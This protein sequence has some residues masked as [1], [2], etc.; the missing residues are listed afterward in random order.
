MLFPPYPILLGLSPLHPVS[1]HQFN[2]LIKLETQQ[3]ETASYPS[4]FLQIATVS[5]LDSHSYSF[6]VFA[7]YPIL[8]GPPRSKYRPS[9][10]RPPPLTCRTWKNE[11]LIEHEDFRISTRI[12]K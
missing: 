8:P 2:K 9:H 7:S 11:I 1:R 10:F 12:L 4:L 3:L 6:L 5:S